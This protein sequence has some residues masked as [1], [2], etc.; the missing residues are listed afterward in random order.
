MP[1]FA[2]AQECMKCGHAIDEA[3]AVPLEVDSASGGHP[4]MWGHRQC[5]PPWPPTPGAVAPP[6]DRLAR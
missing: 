1:R 4:A 5:I 3:D 6:A 2:G